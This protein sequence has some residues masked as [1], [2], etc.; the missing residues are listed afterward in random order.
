MIKN[1]FKIAWRN[2]TK[3]RFYTLVNIVGL[4]TG[5]AFTLLIG[6]YVWGEFQVNRQLKNADRQ[7]ILQSK[8]KDP[9]MGF[10][11]T[12]LA[13]LPKALKTDY[14][15]LV[16]N[17]YLWDGI[18]SNVSKGDKHFR[19]S[20]QIGDS[21]LLN[22][23]GFGLLHG[24]VHTVFTDPFSV[25]ITQAKAIKYFGKTDVV[26]KTVTIESFLGSKHDFTISGVLTNSYENSIL[27]LNDYDNMFLPMSAAKFMGRKVDGWNNPG[28]AGYVELQP[29]IEPKDLEKPIHDLLKKNTSAQIQQNLTPYLVPLKT[30][31]L[32]A[33]KG[34][35]KKMIYTLSFIALFILLMAVINFINMCISQSSSRMKEIGIRKVLGGMK[36]QL[37]WQFLIE[38]TLLVVLAT[39]FAMIIFTLV[40]PVFSNVLGKEIV[41]LSAFPGYFFLIP[42]LL[43]LLV[44]LLAGVYPAFVLSSLKS[45]D[46]LKGKVNSVKESVWMRKLLVGFQFGI[47]VVAFVGALIISQQVNLFFSKNIGYNKDYVVYASVPR[48]WSRK[49][50]QKMEQIRYQFAQ[51]PEVS[52]VSLSWEIPNGSNGGPMQVYKSGADSTESIAAQGIGADNKY[53]ATYNIPLKAGK[54]F[55]DTYA[56]SDS[57]KVVINEMQAKAFGWTAQ[58]AIGQQ[59]HIQGNQNLFTICGVTNDFHFGSMQERIKPITF[60][61]VNFTNFYRYFSFK[62]KPGN[63]QKNIEALQKKWSVLLPD[64]PFEYNFM[65]DALQKV[66]QTEIQLK[67]ASYIATVLAVII[68]LLGILGLISQSIQKRTKEVGIRKV[69]GSSA[70]GIIQLFIKEFLGIVLVAGLFACP[71]AFFIMQKWLSDY[72]YRVT[73]TADPFMIAIGLLTL[74]TVLLIAVQTLKAALANPVKSLRSE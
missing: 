5:I 47:A 28:L 54:F 56:P 48:D 68:V 10:E 67:K 74:V 11:I 22:M 62:L 65:D 35:V 14:P 42:F 13:E 32:S 30:Y 12:T 25:V 36:K 3:N 37:I 71:I 70:A 69:L 51:L 60:I 73:V 29:G 53:A 50:V 7:Y 4:S 38:S 26:G 21:T 27:N 1:Y 55:T 43:A 6:A 59:I 17:Y 41:G 31:Y 46:S 44:G 52:N 61:N 9:N 72:V 33:N 23:Y 57:A 24:N 16:A 39:V 66:Y 40:R 8:W 58:E 64:A 20:I 19:E 49:G 63:T 18:A 34:V 45:V 2:I 15:N